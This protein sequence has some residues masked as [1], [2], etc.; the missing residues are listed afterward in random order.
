VRYYKEE[1]QEHNKECLIKRI[2]YIIVEQ[3]KEGRKKEG[4]K[5]ENA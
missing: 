2:K 3:R 1:G 5:K 4:K